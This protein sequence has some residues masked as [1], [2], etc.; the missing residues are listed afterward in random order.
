MNVSVQPSAVEGTGLAGDG[1][2]RIRSISIVV[3]FLNE[4]AS[5]EE[6]HTRIVAAMAED[7]RQWDLI[8]VDDGSTD[9][10][11]EIAAGLA[12]REDNVQLISFTRNF[13]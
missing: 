5:L 3:P 8:F 1:A 12:A 7:T 9:G 2:R 10:G 6:L 4:E 11:T 13:G